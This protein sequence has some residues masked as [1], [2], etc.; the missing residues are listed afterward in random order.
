[1]VI[2]PAGSSSKLGTVNA[3]SGFDL[4]TVRVSRGL[5]WEETDA[6]PPLVVTCW[7]LISSNRPR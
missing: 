3:I 4:K 6:E 5:Y 7:S 1:M 2:P